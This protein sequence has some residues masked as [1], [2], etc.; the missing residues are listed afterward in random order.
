MEQ[1][2]IH[3]P[4]IALSA[5][6][7]PAHRDALLSTGADTYL[8][9][10]IDDN[11]LWQEIDRL[12]NRD[13]T[14]FRFDNP[15]ATDDTPQRKSGTALPVYDRHE[16]LRVTGGREALAAEMLHKLISDLPSQIELLEQ[17]QE[18]ENWPAL[19]EIAHRLHGACA[20]CGVPALKEAVARL[21]LSAQQAD[22]RE[23]D[24]QM[25]SVIACSRQL[26]SRDELKHET[27][28]F[29]AE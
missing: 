2:D 18:A 13:V 16:A 14:T 22:S 26:Q 12:V 24:Q 15:S 27:G 5:D 7:I 11:K 1:G 29:S 28:Q 8:T 19:G 20:V 9:K 10:P 17:H 3:T 21:E 6:V 4:I 23:I 25:L